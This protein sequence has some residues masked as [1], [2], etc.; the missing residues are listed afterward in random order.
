MLL[1]RSIECVPTNR[2]AVG[3]FRFAENSRLRCILLCMHLG[4]AMFHR[5]FQVPQRSYESIAREHHKPE[6]ESSD[7]FL[8]VARRRTLDSAIDRNNGIEVGLG[9][10]A[11]EMVTERIHVFRARKTGG[12]NFRSYVNI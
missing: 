1:V 10:V 3:T 8:T 5:K 6:V 7:A 2:Y 12:R 4:L 9:I 11:V